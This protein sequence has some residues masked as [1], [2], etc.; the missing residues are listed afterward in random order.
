MFLERPLDFLRIFYPGG[1]WRVKNCGKTI[2]LTFDDGP[3]PQVTPAV[4]DI[5][6]RYGVKATFFCVGDNAVKYPDVYADILNRGHA[7]GN[8]T[9][10]HIKGFEHSVKHYIENVEQAAAHIQ[11]NLFRPPYGRIRPSQLSFLRKKYKVI[12]WD[13]ITRD[14]NPHLSPEFILGNIR[15]LTRTGSIV[16]F[17]DS[18]KSQKNLFAVLPQAIEYWQA[19][20]YAF[21]IL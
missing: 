2:F 12:L 4:L 9:Y 13:I 5:L 8:H 7:V 10:N 3:I 17:H 18:V 14:Y 6:D 21:G 20:G 16:V 19:E 1:I 11:S 15:R